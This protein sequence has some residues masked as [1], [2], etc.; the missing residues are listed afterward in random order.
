MTGCL[1]L[2]F[3]TNYGLLELFLV[4][5]TSSVLPIPTEPTIALLLSENV[6]LLV[7]LLV[8]IP[9]SVLGASVGYLL[10]K[11][12]VRRIIPFH[13]PER[14]ERV[15]AWFGKY[16]AALLIISPWIPFAGDVVP[17]VAGVEE[18]NPTTFLIIMFVAKAI[19]GTA[20]VFFLSFF[21]QLVG[22]HF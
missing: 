13:N 4:S 7:I 5:A 17:I 20:V 10:G 6:N 1:S 8:L 3:I 18:F 19:K 21:V 12:G 2:P 9:A 16:G 11:Y 15:Q 22:V 14:E